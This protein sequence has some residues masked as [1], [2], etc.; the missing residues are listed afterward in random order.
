MFYRCFVDNST[1][2]RGWV[3]SES[4]YE[5]TIKF[6]FNPDSGLVVRIEDGRPLEIAHA[7]CLGDFKIFTPEM[8]KPVKF[9][10]L[11][12]IETKKRG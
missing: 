11:F 9:E 10:E 5:D 2:S 3:R 7:A 8:S 12:E 6:Y 1:I 4:R